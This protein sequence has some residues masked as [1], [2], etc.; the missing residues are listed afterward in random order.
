MLN[1]KQVA[2]AIQNNVDEQINL[3]QS[4]ENLNKLGN[5]VLVREGDARFKS[6]VQG[7]IKS[8]TSL[9]NK[10]DVAE[11]ETLV[12]NGV[13]YFLSE[14]RKNELL[15]ETKR[16][17]S[18][19]RSKFNVWFDKMLNKGVTEG[20]LERHP[21]NAKKIVLV[22]NYQSKD[23]REKNEDSK[24]AYLTIAPNVSFDSFE[25]DVVKVE[26]IVKS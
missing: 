26:Q 2:T 14:L 20:V 9:I 22:D 1:K 21:L 10:D 18:I 8:V 12:Y 16:S 7:S 3:L 6:I 17:C 24:V 11:V 15:K 19:S 13:E 23:M 5:L 25:D 4:N